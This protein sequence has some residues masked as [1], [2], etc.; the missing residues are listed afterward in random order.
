MLW[1]DGSPLTATLNPTSSDKPFSVAEV[2]QDS[3]PDSATWFR[4]RPSV[5]VAD[6]SNWHYGD[7][8]WF[9]RT[10]PKNASAQQGPIGIQQLPFSALAD[11]A[12]G[13]NITLVVE[14]WSDRND[15]GDGSKAVLL[16]TSGTLTFTYD[17]NGFSSK[18]SF[19]NFTAVQTALG[20][21]TLSAQ[22]AENGFYK[23]VASVPRQ[24]K[25][26]V[27]DMRQG[28]C[29]LH[30]AHCNNCSATFASTRCVDRDA[31]LVS[32]FGYQPASSAPAS[33]EDTLPAFTLDTG[34]VGDQYFTRE[35]AAPSINISFSQPGVHFVGIYSAWNGEYGGS[36]G[37]GIHLPA[38]PR[39][40]TT[41]KSFQP[42]AII[43]PWE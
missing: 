30:T 12:P 7:K 11:A 43:T 17:D 33:G 6:P 26:Y 34:L 19:V 40:L 37:T 39:D 31:K 2:R 5:P 3:M 42:F 35:F 28:H 15:L 10:T 36:S 24:R 21:I 1:A 18:A 23:Y 4:V 22:P 9:H 13:T 41:G 16:A 38:W 29:T 27:V 20:A 14:A 25:C 8:C 32:W